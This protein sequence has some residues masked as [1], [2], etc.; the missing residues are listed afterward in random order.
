[1]ATLTQRAVIT[2]AEILAIKKRLDKIEAQLMI[3]TP[4]LPESSES[5]FLVKMLVSI[6]KRPEP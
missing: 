1:M 6:T 3:T 5:P 2:E 4:V